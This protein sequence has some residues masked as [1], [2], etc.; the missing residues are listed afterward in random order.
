[1]INLLCL[2]QGQCSIFIIKLLD[3][4][5]EADY[6]I[7]QNNIK[8]SNFEKIGISVGVWAKYSLVY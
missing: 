2:L 4:I 8:V 7:Y 6:N 1:M 5:I 3:K